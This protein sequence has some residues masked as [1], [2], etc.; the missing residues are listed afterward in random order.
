M[1]CSNPDCTT[2][3]GN[4]MYVYTGGSAVFCQRCVHLCIVRGG[5]PEPLSG[6]ARWGG[7]GQG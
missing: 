3:L 2:V 5:E 6:D 7:Y 1:V 4:G